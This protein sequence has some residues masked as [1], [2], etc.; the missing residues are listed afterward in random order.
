M[1]TKNEIW[2]AIE[3]YEGI[4]QVSNLGRVKR[5]ARDIV[6]K[7]P[8]PASN[9]VCVQHIDERI[10][11]LNKTYNG[12]MLV[13]L[14]G[15]ADGKRRWFSVH[16]LVAMTFLPN[17]DNLPQVNHKNEVRDDNRVENLEW[18]TN[19]Y[20]MH[21]GNCQRRIYEGQHF[22]PVDVYTK[23]GKFLKH[24]N[25]LVEASRATGVATGVVSWICQGITRNR[26]K[27]Q[28]AKGYRFKYSD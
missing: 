22:K 7:N 4:Y 17:P 9:D 16:R 3:G 24:Y 21:Y 28:T 20:N 18:C 25:S 23:D 14:R 10:M 5:L 27:R 19:Y 12:Y 11:N 8:N 26:V 13:H 6:Q 15:A 2:K 1:E